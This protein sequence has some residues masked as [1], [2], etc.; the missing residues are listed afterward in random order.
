MAEAEQNNWYFPKGQF[1]TKSGLNDSGLETFLDN[2]L[3]SLVRETIQNSL[4]AKSPYAKGPVRV[5]FEFFD[6]PI[7]DMPGINSL[8]N[9]YIPK[10]KESWKRDSK[11]YE[12]L[13]TISNQLANESN[14]KIL[15][16]SD[17]NTTG[18]NEGN[19]DAL[20]NEQGVSSKSNN[21]SAGS[22]GIGKNAPF[23]AS[24]FRAVIYNTK[25]ELCE[26][27]IGV[28]IGV[29]YTE[30]ENYVSQARGFLGLSEIRPYEHQYAFSRTRNE[31][32]TDVFVIGVKR[33]YSQSQDIIILNVLENFLLSIFNGTLEVDVD[34][35]PINIDSLSARIDEL[36]FSDD[37]NNGRL[38]NIKNYYSVL[39]SESTQKI[40]L[41]ESI[42]KK[43]PFIDSTSDAVFMLL[44]A[45]NQANATRRVLMARKSGMKIKE[46]GFN[47]GINFSGIFQAT[48]PKLNTFLRSLEGAEHNEWTPERALDYEDQIMAGR[49]IREINSFLGNA[50]RS[51][52]ENGVD[53][54]I[55]AYGL[56]DLLPDENEPESKDEAKNTGSIS[57]GIAKVTINPM[58]KIKPQL[59][60]EENNPD[61]EEPGGNGPGVGGRKTP[62]NNPPGQPAP[63]P[64]S[65]GSS[66]M[67]KLVEVLDSKIR[68]VEIDYKKGLYEIRIIPGHTLSEAY[69][70]LAISGENC[71]YIVPIKSV[72]GEDGFVID[73]GNIKLSMVQAN[74]MT[75]IR[76]K[77]NY[78]YRVR[79]KAVIYESK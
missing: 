64:D 20:V 65:P 34:N 62:T 35:D 1:L 7:A 77:I 13:Q 2:P 15:R 57:T 18:L 32:G 40:Y 30:Q 39:A 16:I 25:T 38:I 3:E 11:E 56:A 55:D 50:I 37:E 46:K 68:P 27:S 75:S 78:D 47:A 54:E 59:R 76:I 41:D 23:A 72:D 44:A 33:K 53:D 36:S 21:Q 52:V 29:S 19:W 66:S 14:I 17:Y 8:I 74:T 73:S 31:I 58:K 12:F 45:D 69:I 71:D 67:P 26:K 43:Y 42:V 48:G 4:D 5:K 63:N 9:D 22:K 51:L 70:K 10:S 24:D 61:I 79:L 28:M 60:F 49:F 6:R